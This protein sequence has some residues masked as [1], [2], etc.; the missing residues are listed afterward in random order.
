MSQGDGGIA[1][2]NRA[3]HER[4]FLLRSFEWI[5]PRYWNQTVD[6]TL[7]CHFGCLS[8]RPVVSTYFFHLCDW[9]SIRAI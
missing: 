7:K 1:G 5:F 4:F 8:K 3:C 2:M 9:R 6:S